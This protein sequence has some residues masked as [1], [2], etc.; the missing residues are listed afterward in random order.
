MHPHDLYFPHIMF[1][2]HAWTSRWVTTSHIKFTLVA[3]PPR[4]ITARARSIRLFWPTDQR[5][6]RKVYFSCMTSTFNYGPCTIR[7][8]IPTDPRPIRVSRPTRSVRVKLFK[9]HFKL[10]YHTR[11]YPLNHLVLHTLI[12]E[13]AG[14]GSVY[15][16][17]DPMLSCL[18]GIYFS[19]IF[20][21]FSSFTMISHNLILSFP[22]HM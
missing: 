10:L 8:V 1:T 7:T 19:S 4:S 6:N 15:I 21:I 18:C 12:Y 22:F 14:S 5:P 20:P 11:P 16:F 3:W 13:V 17:L 2:L 9:S